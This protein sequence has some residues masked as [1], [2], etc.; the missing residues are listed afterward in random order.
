MSL[1]FEGKA[2][3]LVF[4]FSSKIGESQQQKV[5]FLINQQTLRPAFSDKEC[6]NVIGSLNSNQVLQINDKQIEERIFINVSIS[7]FSLGSFI[8]QSS[9]ENL[10]LKN[11]GI[12][13]LRDNAT[14]VRTITSGNGDFIGATG[15]VVVI[16]DET[17]I[18]T[19]LVYF[20]H[21]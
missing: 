1:N 6:K 2:P 17:P 21:I 11:Q 15:Y 16:T 20:T 4:Y 12:Y 3:D 19:N 8:V 14:A 13:R 9:G 5:G 10:V 7:L 18:R